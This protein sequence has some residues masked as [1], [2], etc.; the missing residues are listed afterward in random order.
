MEDQAMLSCNASDRF[1]TRVFAG[2]VVAVA[3]VVSALTHAV[4]GSQAFV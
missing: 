1:H 4:A 3:L 2:L